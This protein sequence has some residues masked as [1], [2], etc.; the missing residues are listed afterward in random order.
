MMC[1]VF[2]YWFLLF[3]G[4]FSLN[5][6]SEWLLIL[7]RGIKWLSSALQDFPQLNSLASN[8]QNYVIFKMKKTCSDKPS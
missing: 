5:N 2:H 8:E 1:I 3:E 6:S 7:L 4:S